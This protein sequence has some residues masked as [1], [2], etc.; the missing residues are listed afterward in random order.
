[1]PF[2]HYKD[3]YFLSVID[4][5]VAKNIH[6]INSNTKTFICNNR[7]S[8]NNEKEITMLTFVSI[9]RQYLKVITDWFLYIIFL[10]D[11]SPNTN[12]NWKEG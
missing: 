7:K 9:S 5:V 11:C 2:R 6:T 12:V 4:F 3:F 1:M 10:F 8:K